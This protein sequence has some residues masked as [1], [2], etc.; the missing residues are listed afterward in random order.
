MSDRK[1]LI[2]E[3]KNTPRPMGV[4]RIHNTRDDKSLI[5]VSKDLPAAMNRHRAQL[6]MGAHPQKQLQADWNAIGADAFEFETLD[7]LE[8]SADAPTYDPTDDLRELE[9]LWLEKLAPSGD[10]GYPTR[11]GRVL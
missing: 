10:P 5:G 8:P 2:R 6:K 11:Q 3:Y 4:F 7:T 9:R 1:A